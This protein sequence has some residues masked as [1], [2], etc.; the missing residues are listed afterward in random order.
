MGNPVSS[1][2][3]SQGKE[4]I[5]TMY[6]LSLLYRPLQAYGS[7]IEEMDRGVIQPRHLPQLINQPRHLP[8]LINTDEGLKPV[9][10]SAAGVNLDASPR[11]RVKDFTSLD[12]F[13][14]SF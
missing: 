12:P 6:Q 10:T 2:L 1:D 11:R 3:G 7:Y 9:M 14:I 4:G 5:S 13:R 8:Q